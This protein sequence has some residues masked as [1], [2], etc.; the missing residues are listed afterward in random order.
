VEN[1]SKNVNQPLSKFAQLLL[2]F[3]S[4]YDLTVPKKQAKVT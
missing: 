2:R 4:G 1:S 3:K